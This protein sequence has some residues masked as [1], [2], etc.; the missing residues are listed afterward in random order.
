MGIYT[1][2]FKKSDLD[3]L[4]PVES[5]AQDEGFTPEFVQAIEDSGLAVT[6]TRNGRIIGCGGVHPSS[7]EQGELWLR[8][9]RSCLRH[10][11]ETLR[12]LREGLKL[13]EELYPF[14]QLN[15][16]IR[17]DFKSSIKLVKF[18]GFKLTQ[19]KTHE[20]K[21]WSIFSKRVKE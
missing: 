7:D 14:K 17:C 12:W 11:L 6:G 2:P 16:I 8:L 20:G 9:S 21:R 4:D 5:L 10:R 13:V 1:R 18:L 19:T 3:A 15:A